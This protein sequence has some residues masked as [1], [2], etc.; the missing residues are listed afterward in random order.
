MPYHR[1][2][3]GGMDRLGVLLPPPERVAS[4]TRAVR[5]V[6]ELAESVAYAHGLDEVVVER[7]WWGR[8]ICRV[9]DMA[10]CS[11]AGS[12][13]EVAETAV[14]LLE[15]RVDGSEPQAPLGG[16]AGRTLLSY[17][18]DSRRGGVIFLGSRRLVA[19]A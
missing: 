3:A 18:I 14:E 15:A 11:E 4:P 7:G 19:E 6:G 16:L 2:R 10:R 9:V 13:D 17:Y 5:L 1:W 12:A 8:R